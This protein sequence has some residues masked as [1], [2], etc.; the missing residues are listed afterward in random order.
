MDKLKKKIKK[1]LALLGVKIIAI[2]LVIFIIIQAVIMPMYELLSW[3]PDFDFIADFFGSFRE[4]PMTID[5][6]QEFYIDK[7]I[8]EGFYSERSDAGEINKKWFEKTG[9]AI[10]A[11]FEEWGIVQDWNDENIR[12]ANGAKIDGLT[13][14]I[15]FDVLEKSKDLYRDAD[16]KEHNLSILNNVTVQILINQLM[17]NITDGLRLFFPEAFT[18][19]V[20]PL[21]DYLR[22]QH[23]TDEKGNF[24][25]DEDNQPIYE[26]YQFVQE[27][28]VWTGQPL[29]KPH[30][31]IA[32]LM[33]KEKNNE[34]Y[35]KE[36][37]GVNLNTVAEY[38]LGDIIENEFGNEVRKIKFSAIYE[39]EDTFEGEPIV[40]K[41][42][43]EPRKYLQRV[44]VEDKFGNPIVYSFVRFNIDTTK[45]KKPLY[46]DDYKDIVDEMARDLINNDESGR[47]YGQYAYT[48]AY[49]DALKL[50]EDE[51]IEGEEYEDWIWEYEGE[52]KALGE[53]QDDGTMLYTA[54]EEYFRYFVYNNEEYDRVKW[55]IVDGKPVLRETPDESWA[56]KNLEY[57]WSLKDEKMVYKTSHDVV[58]F[59]IPS[60][61]DWGL[62]PLF[63]YIQA[64]QVNFKQALSIREE[65]DASEAGEYVIATYGSEFSQAGDGFY[66]KQFE[67]QD[68]ELRNNSFNV[69]ELEYVG[70]IH[71]KYNG[72]F[73]VPSLF[74]DDGKFIGD[75]EFNDE[76]ILNKVEFLSPTVKTANMFDNTTKDQYTNPNKWY[77]YWGDKVSQTNPDNTLIP[78]ISKIGDKFTEA[79]FIDEETNVASLTYNDAKP[80]SL[81]FQATTPF[82]NILYAYKDETRVE[83]E[84]SANDARV[85]I[86]SYFIDRKWI[87]ERFE[88][89]ILVKETTY[90]SSL[91]KDEVNGGYLKNE[92]G[93]YV[94]VW[95]EETK[96]REIFLGTDQV[97]LEI[98]NNDLPDGEYDENDMGKVIESVAFKNGDYDNVK[99][100]KV[101]TVSQSTIDSYD[102]EHGEKETSSYKKSEFKGLKIKLVTEDKRAGVEMP[103]YKVYYGYNMTTRPVLNKTYIDFE[104]EDD[105]NKRLNTNG[106]TITEIKNIEL[107]QES[108]MAYFDDYLRNFETYIP[109]QALTDWTAFDR[110]DDEYHDAVKKLDEV[111]NLSASSSS[112]RRTIKE[113]FDSETWK[114]AFSKM[115]I[116]GDKDEELVSQVMLGLIEE[117]RDLDS[118]NRTGNLNLYMDSDSHNAQDFWD[119]SKS[120][121]YFLEADARTDDIQALNYFS[122]SIGN[123]VLK[124]DGDLLK[125]IQAFYMTPEAMDILLE[126]NK[127]T[128]GSRSNSE[129]VNLAKNYG[130][131]DEPDLQSDIVES[132]LEYVGNPEDQQKLAK[133]S[134][135]WYEEVWDATTNAIDETITTA[136]NILDKTFE[137]Y[138]TKEN[139]GIYHYK[140]D[141]LS[142]DELNFLKARIL[143][144]LLKIENFEDVDVDGQLFTWLSAGRM[145]GNLGG[146]SATGLQDFEPLLYIEGMVTPIELD[147]NGTTVITSPYGMRFHPVY[148]EWR[149]HNGIDI[150]KPNGTPLL[151]IA[152]GGVVIFNDFAGGAGNMLMIKYPIVKGKDTDYI[153]AVYMHMN[154]KSPLKVNDIVNAGD[155]VGYVGNTGTSSNK[156]KG[157]GYNLHFEIRAN[158]SEDNP[159]FDEWNQYINFEQKNTVN[160]F[161]FVVNNPTQD[162]IDRFMQTT[163]R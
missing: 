89:S 93:S 111:R 124:Y 127:D 152:D 101:P 148:H 134:T 17:N 135:K 16:N 33:V 87:A 53:I 99:V 133:T 11:Q 143:A 160:P 104:D 112:Y 138:T 42:M 118:T 91:V 7:V 84:L 5:K 31:Y 55:N 106:K 102:Y 72:G 45:V 147:A 77:M 27:W 137:G 25:F 60:V 115:N 6:A 46:E 103:I 90:S 26:I 151:S 78:L 40:P 100:L 65:R 73:A 18:K 62:A 75:N 14:N 94:K 156:N 109:N 20:P 39:I 58:P 9:D 24:M 149:Y 54:K 49:Q 97:N 163:T 1:I 80:K 51:L 162:Q 52:S 158:I 67:E 47:Y 41:G 43:D 150:G 125:A 145:G 2:A 68:M 126:R 50:Y 29:K 130:G 79:N 131:R 83:S 129:I 110:V 117:M 76:D 22:V 63:S 108:I 153:T 140:G 116:S 105:Y 81:I 157:G 10:T 122:Y 23:A 144:Q 107:E 74:D 48:V 86:G 85:Q 136:D 92:D 69:D 38:E 71:E 44:D 154:S 64:Y 56:N 113:T 15:S 8:E 59:R 132:C 146:T 95:E 119:G 121:N 35:Y 21:K 141:K 161:W 128:W 28:D 139:K 61:A 57:A 32:E 120:T 114:K 34:D 37:D 30:G 70:D 19:P 123:L 142:V 4:E 96:E 36:A 66:P 155:V 3:R 82:Q 88:K 98:F 13:Q 159:Y 12:D